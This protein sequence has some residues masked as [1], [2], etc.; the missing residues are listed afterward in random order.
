MST[1]RC[2]YGGGTGGL[3]RQTN[4][5][6]DSL[7]GYE[8]DEL[9]ELTVGTLKPDRLSSRHIKNRNDYFH[10]QNEDVEFVV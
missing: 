1:A 10:L 6:A 3:I 8:G 7:F 9:L 2:D 5:R 4:A